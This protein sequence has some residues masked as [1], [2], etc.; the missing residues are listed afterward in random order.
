MPS[1]TCRRAAAERRARRASDRLPRP[2]GPPRVPGKAALRQA[3]RPGAR[4]PPRRHRRRRGR[5]GR[6]GRLPVRGQG[7]GAD[8]RARQGR[9][10]QDRQRRDEAREH[11]EAILGMDI[12]GLHRPRGLGRARPRRSPP[13]TTPRSSSTAPRRSCWRCS[14][15]WAAWT[16]R[17]S[18]RRI[19]SALVKRHIEPGEELR[20]RRRRG[21]IAIDA[22][23]DEDVD[24]PGR[25][26]CWSSCTRSRSPRTRP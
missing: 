3:R 13:S 7:P 6:G 24:R 1:G 16:S 15:A 26:G 8:R 4:R 2:S 22:R 21:Q 12:R 25:R 17:R 20:R 9:R 5:G 19:P 23:I 10:D 18:P 11:A 14:R